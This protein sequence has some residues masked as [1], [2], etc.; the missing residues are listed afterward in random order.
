[1][2][3]QVDKILSNMRSKGKMQDNSAKGDLGEDAVLYLCYER[4]QRLPNSL[5]FQS[6][7]YPYQTDKSDVCYTGNIKYENGE[8]T[9]Y[10]RK[11][12]EDEID[13]LYITPYRIFPI[14]VKSYG[15]TR[16]DIY[17]HWFNRRNTPVDKSPIAQAE[18]HAR[19]LY[20]AIYDVIPDG[21]PD[22][23]VPMVCFVDKCVIRD[24]RSDYFQNYI[25]VCT[26]NRFKETLEKY[27]KPLQY[28]LSLS[29]IDAKLHK[30]KTSVR[31]VL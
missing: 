31:R 4:K 26:L 29:D 13:V 25:P 6:F 5:L 9:E 30:I 1:M 24:D 27:N 15:N 7:K 23:I 18:K 10:T 11:G 2:A 19:H 17:D 3:S 22:Y 14:E 21:N 28:N 20:H 12:L 16:L 8:F